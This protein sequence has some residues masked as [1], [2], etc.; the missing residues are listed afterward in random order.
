MT[1]I[2]AALALTLAVGVAALAPASAR[3]A[4]EVHD[5]VYAVHDGVP[6]RGDLYLPAGDGPFP[7]ML[8]VHGGAWI[9][10]N[11]NGYAGWGR[12]LAARGYAVF[13][14][15]YRLATPAQPTWPLFLIDVK[16]AIQ[17]L[18]GNA[19]ALRIDPDRIGASGGSAGGQITAMLALTG[20]MP[21][22]ANPYPDPHRHLSTKVKVA[23][24][25]YGVFDMVKWW[26]YTV[27]SRTDMPLE[28]TFGGTP[29]QL[30]GAYAAASPL[31]YVTRDNPN[32]YVPWFVSWGTEDDVVPEHEHSKVFVRELL[33]IQ[34]PVVQAQVPGAGHF[35]HSQDEIT[36]EPGLPAGGNDFILDRF[37]RFL[38]ENL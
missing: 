6:L 26:E 21:Q 27:V 10:G 35:W 24:P 29:A 32:A 36:G 38:E 34:A 31:T 17:Y 7:A 14:V 1:R 12:Y 3:A 4:T 20:D 2:I 25:V 30:P 9:R 16:S 8:F 13:S 22:F 33:K 19:A 23:A 18:R 11:E 37:M 5:V 15:T 28:Q